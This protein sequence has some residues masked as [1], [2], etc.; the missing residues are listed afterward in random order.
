MGLKTAAELALALGADESA[1]TLSGTVVRATAVGV[2]LALEL[3]AEPAEAG[4]ERV[5]KAVICAFAGIGVAAGFFEL[6]LA[7]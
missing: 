3:L 5:K 2:G 4:A 7:S 6:M 1:T